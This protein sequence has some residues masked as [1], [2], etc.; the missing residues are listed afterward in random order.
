[1]KELSI[2]VDESGDFGEYN[3]HSPYYIITMVFHD[4]KNSIKE[5]MA[6]LDNEF[7]NMGLKKHCVHSGPII[8]GE[9][10][11][12]YMDMQQRRKIFNK[13]IAFIRRS[14]IEYHCFHIEKKHIRDM[15]D[16]TG[17]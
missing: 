15:I 3:H 4:Q 11:Y 9:D 10:E 13:M 14:E 16:A 17:K 7:E 2:F 5:A 1:M 12:R 6:I 8:R